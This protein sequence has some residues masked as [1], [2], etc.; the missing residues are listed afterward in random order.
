MKTYPHE[1]TDEIAFKLGEFNF[2]R[3]Y[4]M[5]MWQPNIEDFEYAYFFNWSAGMGLFC[6]LGEG[7]PHSFTGHLNE[8]KFETLNHKL[9]YIQGRLSSYSV[10]ITDTSIHIGYANSHKSRDRVAKWL[11]EIL[12]DKF[13]GQKTWLITTSD[14][15]KTTIPLTPSVQ[16]SSDKEVIDYITG[17]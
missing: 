4:D 12:K 5:A 3:F 15:L 1:M 13:G 7:N 2:P 14:G 11:D 6:F 8:S 9:K 17:K 16:I 10:T